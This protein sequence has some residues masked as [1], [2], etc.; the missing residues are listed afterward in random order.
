MIQ[1]IFYK[2]FVSQN[3]QDTCN[4]LHNDDFSTVN[5]FSDESNLNILFLEETGVQDYKDNGNIELAMK[6]NFSYNA[7]S[8]D[9]SEMN[10]HENKNNMS[11]EGLYFKYNNDIENC[12]Y[13]PVNNIENRQENKKELSILVLNSDKPTDN[14]TNL[15]NKSNNIIVSNKEDKIL[16]SENLT[17]KIDIKKSDNNT[18]LLLGNKRKNSNNNKGKIHDNLATDNLLKSSKRLIINELF[19]FIN[20]KIKEIYNNNIGNGLLKK[21]LKKLSQDQI[22]NTR[23]SDNIEFLNKSLENI[24]SEKITGRVT[25]CLSSKNIEI[26]K[27]LREEEDIEKKEYFNGLFNLTFFQCLKHFRGEEENT[28]IKGLKK[29]SELINKNKIKEKGE[30]YIEH[31]KYFLDNYEIILSNKKPRGPK[32]T[33]E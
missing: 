23:L 24:F 12:N 10:F 13:L 2:D 4:I 1:N 16:I 26:I 6:K 15:S 30:D 3:D 33:N 31:L 21:E 19:D 8:D 20:N 17:K 9:F 18:T 25:N 22:V 11:G 14:F 28:Y 27:E 29:F 7:D 5:N 32:T